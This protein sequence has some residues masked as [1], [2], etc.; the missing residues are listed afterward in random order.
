MARKG[1]AVQPSES[2]YKIN[3]IQ[4]NNLKATENDQSEERLQKSSHLKDTCFIR[5][6]LCVYGFLAWENSPIHLAATTENFSLI[7]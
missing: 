1:E 4:N 3:T 5:Y 6:E 2:H 7:V